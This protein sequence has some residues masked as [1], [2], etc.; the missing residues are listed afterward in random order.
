[1]HGATIK[2]ENLKVLFLIRFSWSL[3]AGN[4]LT[5]SSACTEQEHKNVTVENFAANGVECHD[6]G[7]R[8]LKVCE[9]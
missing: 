2:K 1:M 6:F 4:R 7:V 3:W 8:G 5:R 9:H